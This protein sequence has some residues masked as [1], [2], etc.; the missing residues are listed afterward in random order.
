MGKTKLDYRSFS[1]HTMVVIFSK[2]R[3]MSAGFTTGQNEYEHIL[4]ALHR[5]K[6]QDSRHKGSSHARHLE[7]CTEFESLFP[8]FNP[9]DFRGPE[10]NK[11]VKHKCLRLQKW[12][13]SPND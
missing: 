3:F 7:G 1:L 13:L 8:A 4:C 2:F 11:I 9:R 5:A 10:T 12:S 6:I